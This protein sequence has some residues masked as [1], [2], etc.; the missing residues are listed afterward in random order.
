MDAWSGVAEWMHGQGLL[1]GCKNGFRPN[2]IGAT[3]HPPSWGYLWVGGGHLY[4]C[5]FSGANQLVGN[6]TKIL[7]PIMPLEAAHFN[8]HRT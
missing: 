8:Q 3:T 2:K 7:A 5:V 6:S 4:S 1:S